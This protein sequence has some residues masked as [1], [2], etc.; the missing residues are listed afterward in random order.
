[1]CQPAQQAPLNRLRRCGTD[2][3]LCAHVVVRFPISRKQNVLHRHHL[4]RRR[5]RSSSRQLGL[6]A[7][8]GQRQAER[9]RA[10]IGMLQKPQESQLA[11]DAQRVLPH[12]EHPID[13]LDGHLFVALGAAAP[14]PTISQ[15]TYQ[16]AQLDSRT[17]AQPW[18]ARYP[19][20]RFFCGGEAILPER[21]PQR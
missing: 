14:S 3:T 10:Y 16:P 19:A 9:D 12:L 17:H 1:M 15:T 13:V 5:G 6:A 21:E 7:A 2:V 4:Q 11:Y 18:P 20:H 8:R